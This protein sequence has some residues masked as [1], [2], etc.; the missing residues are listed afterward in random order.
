[1]P[2]LSRNFDPRIGPLIQV[3]VASSGQLRPLTGRTVQ[4]AQKE[5]NVYELLVDTG[6][7]TTCISR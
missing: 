3:I 5:L 7:D 6:A 2:V 1:M 4:E